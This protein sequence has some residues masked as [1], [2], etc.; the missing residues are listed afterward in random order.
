SA[1][2]GR[3]IVSVAAQRAY[4]ADVL[5]FAVPTVMTAIGHQAGRDVSALFTGNR[6]EQGAYLGVPLLAVVLA[7]ALTRWR[8]RGARLLLA[9]TVL[10]ALASMG[11][12]LHVGG[13]T[14]VR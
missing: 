13:L 5:N 11:P 12:R 3:T 1:P 6:F 7:F 10:A 14:R 2:H 9:F 4:S 8:R